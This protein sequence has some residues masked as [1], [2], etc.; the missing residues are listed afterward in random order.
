MEKFQ[1]DSKDD[2][3]KE[4]YQGPGPVLASAGYMY[5]SHGAAMAASTVALG[6]AGYHADEKVAKVSNAFA[7]F[8]EH[9]ISS[10][11]IAMRWS[12]KTAAF[13][14]KLAEKVIEAIPGSAKWAA[15][16]IVAKRWS[17]VV[18]AGGLGAAS[19]W[20]A[21]TLWGIAKGRHEG[22]KGKRQFERAKNEIKDLRERNDDLEKI[23]D[24]LHQDVIEASSQWRRDA[25]PQ[26][27]NAAPATNLNTVQHEGTLA[28]QKELA[29]A[30]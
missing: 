28:P 23:N 19:A 26:T 13:I 30:H 18:F 10:S 27:A 2:I 20:L 8:A 4:K 3:V 12:A 29:A 16:P 5:L 17:S 24:K 1:V 14:P 9:H 15:N 7:T 11:N 25:S 22:N 6:V 21:T